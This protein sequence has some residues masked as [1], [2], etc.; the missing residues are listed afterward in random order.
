MNLRLVRWSNPELS[1]L[2][3][4][5]E[6]VPAFLLNHEQHWFAVRRFGSSERFYSLDSQLPQPQWIS[7]M[8]L[9][10]S[11]FEAERSGACNQFIWLRV[12]H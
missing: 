5:P 3:K 8:Y 2:H 12:S 7:A 6:L 10:L 11:L 4:R 1:H 9:G